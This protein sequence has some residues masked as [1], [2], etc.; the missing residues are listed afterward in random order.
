MIGHL[1]HRVSALLDGQLSARETEEAWSHVYSCHACRDLVEREGW[2]KTRLAG[3]CGEDGAAPSTLKGSLLSMPPHATDHCLIDPGHRDRRRR[4]IGVVFLGG[5]AVGATM[6][7]VLALGFAPG[8]APPADRRPPAT[9]ID[10]DLA[11]SDRPSDTDR[12]PEP[13]RT[14]PVNRRTTPAPTLA[15]ANLASLIA[16]MVP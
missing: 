11:P 12:D 7:G 6:V 3:L 16:G 13:A 10:T 2:I 14:V 15:P 4:A 1:G 8:S 9:Q 5:S